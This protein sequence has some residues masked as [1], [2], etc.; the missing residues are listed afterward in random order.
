MWSLLLWF[1]AVCFSHESCCSLTVWK[2]VRCG[3]NVPPLLAAYGRN[4]YCI[5]WEYCTFTVL[6]HRLHGALPVR[7]PADLCWT[8]AFA[9]LGPPPLPQV[10]LMMVVHQEQGWREEMENKIMMEIQLKEHVFKVYRHIF[11]LCG[12]NQ[13][14]K[15]C[16]CVL[17]EDF[18]NDDTFVKWSLLLL[19]FFLSG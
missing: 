19:F 2:V 13:R 16:V 14:G 18:Q 6:Q 1:F 11:F 3:D 4:N 15:Y 17:L 7:V 12:V 5:V 10:H 8:G 9:I